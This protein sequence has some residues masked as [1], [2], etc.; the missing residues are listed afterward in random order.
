MNESETVVRTILT[1][2]ANRISGDEAL[3]HGEPGRD[4]R[5]SAE[6][7]GAWVDIAGALMQTAA[8]LGGITEHEALNLAYVR[9]SDNH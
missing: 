9:I 4:V 6:W 8:E 7:V 3:A 1:A 5:G 2:M